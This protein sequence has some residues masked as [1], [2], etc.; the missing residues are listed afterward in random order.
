MMARD[1]HLNP[2]RETLESKGIRRVVVIDDC[3]DDA[4]NIVKPEAVEDFYT[5][6]QNA[7]NATALLKRLGEVCERPVHS[8]EDLPSEVITQLDKDP[9]LRKPFDSAW[10]PVAQ[11]LQT[12]GRHQLDAFLKCLE[13]D[14]GLEVDRLGTLDVQPGS[15]AEILF[16]DY[17]LDSNVRPKD[18]LDP[19]TAE[20][21]VSRAMKRIKEIYDGYEE[22]A[23]P[24]VVLMSNHPEGAE[25][26]ARKFCQ[27]SDLLPGV[28][29]FAP[30][31]ELKDPF[32]L[33]F[34]MRAYAMASETGHSLQ[35]FIHR[36]KKEAGSVTERFV[37]EV[38]QLGVSDYAYIQNMSLR[39]DGQPL[40]EYLTW[41]FSC[42]LTQRLFAETLRKERMD[43]DRVVYPEAQELPSPDDLSKLVA[44][45]YNCAVFD[46]ST[47][48]L[49]PHPTQGCG[50]DDGKDCFL[51]LGD[52]FRSQQAKYAD[53]LV[54][55]NPACDL[56]YGSVS[57][58]FNKDLAILLLPGELTPLAA[59]SKR[60]E[61]TNVILLE[62]GSFRITWNLKMV[63]S[64]PFGSLRSRLKYRGYRLV[65]QMRLPHALSLQNEVARNITRVGTPVPPPS[66]DRVPVE[67]RVENMQQPWKSNQALDVVIIR[68]RNERNLVIP[69]SVLL[70]AREALEDVQCRI[71][72]EIQTLER[73][74]QKGNE[75]SKLIQ[76]TKIYQ[77]ALA[78]P[79]GW[80]QHQEPMKWP[81]KNHKRLKD[82]AVS[83]VP[84]N[85][86]YQ[87]K[88]PVFIQLIKSDIESSEA[89]E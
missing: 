47:R 77:S 18:P 74:D 19:T 87:G 82:I 25:E 36:L 55:I 64:V 33:A 11:S 71:T 1:V 22:S 53:L 9:E 60:L 49:G 16:V 20:P 10:E 56:A 2:V 76:R 4:G 75:R 70:V 52:V 44:D 12:Y 30:K 57:R 48:T 73:E 59:D 3:F 29:F 35:R 17:V 8:S 5:R 51:S 72:G 58:R 81:P 85:E 50:D 63:E 41:L 14:L 38:Q 34:K 24:V 45:L 37:E 83:I 46:T 89:A 28:F 69:E 7:D 23:K 78:H 43:L 54:V 13:E 39:E 86:T 62:G 42:S 40:G 27:D 80:F 31:R 79:E 26:G 21:G 65:A 32:A 66:Y 61:G 84:E 67:I 88:D 6:I 68:S 15:E